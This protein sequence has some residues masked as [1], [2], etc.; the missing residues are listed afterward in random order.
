MKS[1]KLAVYARN[2]INLETQEEL[3]RRLTH[4]HAQASMISGEGLENFN[5]HSDAI[6]DNYL[7]SICELAEQALDLVTQLSVSV[8]T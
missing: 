4:L 1:T 8:E 2:S 7:W 6:K 5:N 3:R